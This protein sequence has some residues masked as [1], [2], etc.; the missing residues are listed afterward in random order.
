MKIIIVAVV[1]LFNLLSMA[2]GKA[3]PPSPFIDVGACPFECCKYGEWVAKTVIELQDKVDG[4]IIVGKVNPGEKVVALTGEVRTIPT[5]VEVLRDHGKFKKGNLLYLLTYQGEGFYKVW[6]NGTISS[7]EILFPGF[8]DQY[9]FKNCDPSK[10]DCWGKI[11]NLKR[12]SYWWVKI[13]KPDGTT[14]WTNQSKEFIG[15]DSCS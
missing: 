13:K 8:N 3:K 4:S 1:C 14:G 12:K 7:E 6:L 2:Q 15:Q 10:K 5:V 9:D 11:R